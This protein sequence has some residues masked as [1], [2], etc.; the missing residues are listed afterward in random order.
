MTNPIVAID[1]LSAISGGGLSVAR[2]LCE[3]LAVARPTW[4][5]LMIAS[6]DGALPS[7]V[8]ANVEPIRPASARSTLRRWHFE[9]VAL[10]R[11]LSRHDVGAVL[12][13]GGFKIFASDCPQAAV[14]Q[15]AHIWT[16]PVASQGWRLSAYIALQKIVMRATVSRVERNVFLSKDSA[17]RARR[18]IDLPETSVDIAPIGIDAHFYANTA[19]PPPFARRDPYLLAVGDVYAHKRFELAIDALAALGAQRRNRAPDRRS[20]PRC[21]ELSRR[22]VDPDQA[23]RLHERVGILGYA[24]ARTPDRAMRLGS[25]PDHRAASRPSD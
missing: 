2:G 6:H 13:L 8:P 20:D 4:T 16:P 15:N 12:L 23:E 7:P 5:L 21:L 1:A 19:P 24:L 18:S 10:P 14:W 22:L 11:V 9:Q 3:S 17:D 25:S